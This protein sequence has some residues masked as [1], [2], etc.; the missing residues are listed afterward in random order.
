MERV[1]RNL[2]VDKRGRITLPKEYRVGIET[3]YSEKLADGSIK[4]VPQMPV[5]MAEAK[6]LESLRNSLNSFKKGKT[7]KVPS[8]WID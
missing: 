4:L 3:F 2:E 6:V 5:S 8:K 1:T 7:K